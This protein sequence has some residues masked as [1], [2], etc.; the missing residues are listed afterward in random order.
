MPLWLKIT[1]AVALGIMVIRLWPTASNMLKNGPKGSS[2][3]WRAAI[4]PL[5][6]VIGFVILLI[7][8][9]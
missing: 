3:D 2:E 4:F 5:L 6:M 1:V 7:L 9:V 8:M